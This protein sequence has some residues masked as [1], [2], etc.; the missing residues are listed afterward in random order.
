MSAFL[1]TRF[2]TP[3][4]INLFCKVLANIIPWMIFYVGTPI[5]PLQEATAR[6]PEQPT[7]PSLHL[8]TKTLGPL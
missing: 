6:Q 3:F 8:N 5:T 2:L 7:E 1:T 4:E